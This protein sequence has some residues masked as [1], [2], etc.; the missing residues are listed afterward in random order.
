MAYRPELLCYDNIRVNYFHIFE[1]HFHSSSDTNNTP[2]I[3]IHVNDNTDNIAQKP[4]LFHGPYLCPRVPLSLTPQLRHDSGKD[5]VD[6]SFQAKGRES[7][8][9]RSPSVDDNVW[10]TV[11][12]DS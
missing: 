6:V 8:V 12:E 2:V 3:I 4:Q 1:R 11:L 5:L 7:I 10:R 9:D